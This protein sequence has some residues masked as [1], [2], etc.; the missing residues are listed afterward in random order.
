MVTQ[1]LPSELA[2][3]R[4]RGFVRNGCVRI[5]LGELANVT[6]NP[7]Q[8]CM[9]DVFVTLEESD[10]GPVVT[11]ADD[12]HWVVFRVEASERCYLE[13]HSRSLFQQW[14]KH[15][16]DDRRAARSKFAGTRVSRLIWGGRTAYVAYEIERP[17]LVARVARAL[18]SRM[19]CACRGLEQ[20][21]IPDSP[22]SMA[23][24]YLGCT[25]S[26]LVEKFEQRFTDGMDWDSFGGLPGRRGWVI[27]HIVPL[28]SFDL[29]KMSHVRR[30]CHHS[31]L[32]P[33]WE[34]ENSRKRDR[35]PNAELVEL[36]QKWR[37]SR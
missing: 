34:S 13:L 4:R 1:F 15:Y 37:A 20:T 7:S 35:M 16:H 24:N 9:R 5:T 8:L 10:R 14:N 6:Q 32:R 31:N 18:K 36:S 3:A 22:A 17:F 23:K 2:L 11:T 25:L 30:A 27:D 29:R 26:A 28:S 19:F 21:E 33:C 12:S